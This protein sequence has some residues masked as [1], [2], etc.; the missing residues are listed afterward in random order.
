M[1]NISVLFCNE[2]TPDTCCSSCHE[3]WDEG[4]TYPFENTEIEEIKIYHCCT[5]RLTDAIK[6]GKLKEWT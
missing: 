4:Y 6:K 2:L 1:K 3:E 5:F